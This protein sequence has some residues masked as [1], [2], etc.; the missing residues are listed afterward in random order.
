MR[1]G[2]GRQEDMT[3]EVGEEERRALADSVNRS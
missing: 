3:V 1:D 2:G